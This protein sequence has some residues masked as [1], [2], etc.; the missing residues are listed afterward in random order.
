M[1]PCP[2]A[3]LFANGVNGGDLVE[4]TAASLM[5]DVRVTKFTASKVLAARDSFLASY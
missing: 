4:M 2:A 3:T 5:A 1:L